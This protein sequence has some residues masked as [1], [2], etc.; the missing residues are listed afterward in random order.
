MDVSKTELKKSVYWND[1][2]WILKADFN[3]PD[4]IKL[5]LKY[6]M[7]QRLYNNAFYKFAHDVKVKIKNGKR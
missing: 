7:Q 2:K 4:T 5:P 6:R 3:N 1:I